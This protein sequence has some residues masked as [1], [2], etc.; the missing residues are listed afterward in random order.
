MLRNAISRSLSWLLNRIM[1]QPAASTT[2][3]RPT[4]GQLPISPEERS[5]RAVAAQ[6]LLENPVLQ[7]AVQ[8]MEADLL[9]QMQ[10]VSLADREAHT[11]LM[12]GLQTTQAVKRHLWRMIQ[13]GAAAVEQ[14]RLRGR[15]ID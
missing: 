7:E 1:N 14:I 6:Q 10:H 3:P 4:S 15:R 12:I 9:N 2:W 11:R 8:A 13:D 5:R